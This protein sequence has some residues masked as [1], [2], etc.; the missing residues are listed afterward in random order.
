M[1]LSITLAI[2]L[3]AFVYPIVLILF[4]F[5]NPYWT[6]WRGL[7]KATEGNVSILEILG[8]I[9]KAR[10][11][12]GLNQQMMDEA[13]IVVF[14]PSVIAALT[15]LLIDRF[16]ILDTASKEVMLA[17]LISNFCLLVLTAVG[18]AFLRM[19]LNRAAVLIIG[20]VL[21]NWALVGGS[22]LFILQIN[23]FRGVLGNALSY[24]IILV[25][26]FFLFGYGF[27]RMVR[28][29][30]IYASGALADKNRSQ[31]S[32]PKDKFLVKIAKNA[33][34]AENCAK[35]GYEKF[36]ELNGAHIYRKENETT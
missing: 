5:V 28:G 32:Q 6:K 13:D 8:F 16:L 11:A 22:L 31:P 34:E 27:F 21:I 15:A 20:E 3:S 33:E 7:P 1:I 12:Q 26:V 35:E 14:A 23:E 2:L 4:W 18:K 25:V 9:G 19:A 17:F 10:L 29:A 30:D 24:L 36:D